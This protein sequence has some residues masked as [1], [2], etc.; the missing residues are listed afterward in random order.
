M[1]SNHQENVSGDPLIFAVV[2]ER[3]IPLYVTRLGLNRRW[4]SAGLRCLY[5]GLGSEKKRG[6]STIGSVQL[7]QP[8]RCMAHAV[9]PRHLKTAQ[10]GCE[11]IRVRSNR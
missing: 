2:S 5:G 11:L 1:T 8:V 10:D 4:L 7:Q 6:D 3:I 9:P